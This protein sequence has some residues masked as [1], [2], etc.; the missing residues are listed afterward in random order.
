MF[1]TRQVERHGARFPTASNGAQIQLA[2]QKL[3]AVKE[4]NDPQLEFLRN[5]TYDLGHDDL[6]PFGAAQ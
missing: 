5:F 1:C 4:F 6:V 2:V 3:Q